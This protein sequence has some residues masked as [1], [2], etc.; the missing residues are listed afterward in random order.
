MHKPDPDLK[1]LDL[2]F[3]CL[4]RINLASFNTVS[5]RKLIWSLIIV[6]AFSVTGTGIWLYEIVKLKGWYNLSWLQETLFAPYFLTLIA[7]MAFLVPFQ[8]YGFADFRKIAFPAIILYVISI[9]CYEAGKY[10][11]F[12]TYRSFYEFSNLELIYLLSISLLLFLVIGLSYWLMSNVWMKK[13]KKANAIFIALFALLT[14]PLSMISVKVIPGFGSG[15]D[16][17]DAVKMGYPVFWMIAS[18]GISG[19]MI[20][21]QKS[22]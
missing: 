20:S 10:L 3:P 18:L 15:S 12:N 14:I 11:C 7:V 5:S 2:F 17:I 1:K 22:V 4:K 21:K 9:V 19:L 13:N 16:W 6:L 8:I